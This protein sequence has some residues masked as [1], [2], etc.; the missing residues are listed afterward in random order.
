MAALFD[1]QRAA[2]IVEYHAR[3]DANSPSLEEVIDA[4]LAEN[5]PAPRAS[6]GTVHALAAEVQAAVYTRTVEALLTLAADSKNSAAVRAITYAK[7]DDIKR[8]ANSTSPVEAYL[9]H[10]ISQFQ[11]DPA[12]FVVASPVP[13][14]PGMPIGDEEL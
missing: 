2:R 3:T 12:K 11:S 8:H 1:P 4:A 10:R 5:R 9:M 13:A 7:L 6:T 14:P